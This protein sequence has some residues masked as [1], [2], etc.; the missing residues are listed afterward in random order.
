M[1]L[2]IDGLDKRWKNGIKS[3]FEGELGWHAPGDVEDYA[4][5]IFRRVRSNL[6]SDNNRTFDVSIIPR[7][8]FT[9]SEVEDV[10]NVVLEKDDYK[11]LKMTNQSFREKL[12]TN[13]HKRWQNK[14]VVWPSRT[15]KLVA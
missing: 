11:I 5:L 2:N 1:L 8:D 10:E 15:G 9:Y 12:V 4:P 14:D 7:R 3:P 13:F 6:V